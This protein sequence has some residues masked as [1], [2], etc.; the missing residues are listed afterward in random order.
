MRK[1]DLK[2]FTPDSQ[3][4]YFLLRSGT[5]PFLTTPRAIEE[6]LRTVEP[7]YNAA[8]DRLASGEIDREAIYAIS[9]FIAFVLCCSPAAMRIQSVTPRT[10][11]EDLLIAMD[12]R[13]EILA[14]PEELGGRTVTE[15][16]RSGDIKIVV[17]PKYS[18]AVGTTTIDRIIQIF[19]NCH[20]DILMNHIDEN[21]FFTSDFPIA[22]E[23]TRDPRVMNRIVPLAPNLAVR[24][25]PDISLARMPLD[26]S[27][28]RF[29]SARRKLS[30]KEVANLNRLLVRCAE[31]VV[32]YRDDR[33][34]VR[35]FIEKN[36]QFRVELTV[37]KFPDGQGVLTFFRETIAESQAPSP[38]FTILPMAAWII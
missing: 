2:T 32:F 26:F 27:F 36:R 14:P 18:Q 35:M 16:L 25:R 11:L 34:W 8:V 23:T 29:R 28:T 4:V 17:D 7:K 20:W 13:G 21:P 30:R 22:V 12:A 1:S 31:D 10:A 5:N 33:P 19:G 3:S 24:I 38:S 37:H 15:I 6:F 9:G